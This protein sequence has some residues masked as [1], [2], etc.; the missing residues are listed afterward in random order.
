MPLKVTEILIPS[1]YYDEPLAE[2]IMPLRMRLIPAGNF[3]MGSPPD[4]PE[5]QEREGP[6]HV[7]N[8]SQ[9]FMSQYP[10]TQAQWRFVAEL[11]QQ[12]QE[13][14]LNPSRFKGDKRPVERVSWH[15]AVEFCARLTNYTKR[16]YRLP[17]EAEWEYSCRAV[18][19]EQLSVISGELTV[20]EWN[21]WLCEPFH[22]GESIST[23]YANYNVVDNK[24][25]G[26]ILLKPVM[27]QG[28]TTPV[29]N[30]G[31][32]NA[33]GLSDMHG[34]IWEWCAD[35]WHDN[36]KNAPTDGS[37]WFENVAHGH[38]VVRGGSW[39]FESQH[40]RSSYRFP[41]TPDLRIHGIGFR[42]ACSTSVV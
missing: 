6:Q 13:L 39:L 5:R 19:P 22:F 24:N 40:C 11:P 2:R 17:S 18:T 31:V 34:N 28:E 29:D 16:P 10:I 41:F 21:K 25:K 15:D 37:V 14:E 30:F 3:V 23:D 33:F 32:T 35:P 38:C 1:Q 9:F 27:E 4:E 7:V 20:E 26:S 8:V 42:V 36:Y 12:A